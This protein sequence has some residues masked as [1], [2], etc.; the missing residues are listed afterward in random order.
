MVYQF[1]VSDGSLS[2]T[3][4]DRTITV[5]ITGTN[6]GPTITAAVTEDTTAVEAGGALNG[7]LGVGK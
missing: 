4:N 1:N 7:D 6:D 2:T 3:S 5:T